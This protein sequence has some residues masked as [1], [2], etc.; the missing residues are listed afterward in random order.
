MDAVLNVLLDTIDADI[1]L[2]FTIPD[3]CAATITTHAPG[4]T[5]FLKN[6]GGHFVNFP[7]KKK[8]KI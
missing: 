4:L 7:W 1:D 2:Y 8:I 3:F 5:L 6:F